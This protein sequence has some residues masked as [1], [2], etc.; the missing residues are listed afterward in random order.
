M[1]LYE[2]IQRAHLQPLWVETEQYVPRQPA[3]DAAPAHWPASRTFAL[4]REAGRAVPSELADRRVLVCNNPGLPPFSGTTQTLYACLQQLLPGE[5]ADEHRH[6][7]SAFRFILSG[8][9]AHTLLN[10]QRIP[11]KRGDFIV[12][13]AWS[14]HGH[15]NDSTN[16][17]IWLD[18]LD[19]AIV[20]LFGATFF[21]R[22]P[23]GA[24]PVDAAADANKPQ[25]VYD[26]ASTRQ[27]IDEA[28]RRG[29]IDAAHGY[30]VRYLDPRTGMDPL[31]TIA[32]HLSELPSGFNGE[33]Y[34]SSDGV[35]FAAVRGS[36]RTVL[37][38]TSVDWTE[39]DIFTVPTWTPYHHVASADAVLFS[40]SD[41]A[42]QERLDCWREQRG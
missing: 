25:L 26:W 10:R 5:H 24:L 19:N 12:A 40:F 6:S 3:S 36:G 32:A 18:G 14:W 38:H 20:R 35:V 13:P 30:R 41:R 22:A 9:G 33:S 1:T 29:A 11:M 2:E 8:D 7:Q 31:P 23:G 39:N 37:E 27:R 21:E 15:G 34:R 17:V 28:R 4:L 42:A 16:E